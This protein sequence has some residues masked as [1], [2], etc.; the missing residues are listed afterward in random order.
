MQIKTF[1]FNPIGENTYILYDTTNECV[2][3]DPGCFYAEEKSALLDFISGNNLIV[4]HVLNTHMHFDHILGNNFMFE[5]FGLK[6]EANWEDEFLLNQFSAQMRT[7]GIEGADEKMPPIGNY[8][9]DNDVVTF[10]S[11]QLTV[12]HIPG[13]SPGSV[14]FYNREAK[15][16]I[17]GDVLFRGSIGRTDLARGNYGQLVNGIKTKLMTLSPDTVVY[18]GHGPKT[19]IG[20]EAAHNP[21]LQ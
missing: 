17:A 14:V 20:F 6:P 12:L 19:T 8:L 7:F 3:I 1:Q 11:Q 2:V 21:F 15:V 5:Q 9:E 16:L 18:P 13:H 10:G 4:R